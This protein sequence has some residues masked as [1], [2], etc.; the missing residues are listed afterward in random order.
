MILLV[1]AALISKLKQR[2]ATGEACDGHACV[3][4]GMII[5]V[6]LFLITL[7]LLKDKL[8]QRVIRETFGETVAKRF[9][10]LRYTMKTAG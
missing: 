2:N 6:L 8:K 3:N 5:C 7:S 4:R 9:G 10:A 1:F